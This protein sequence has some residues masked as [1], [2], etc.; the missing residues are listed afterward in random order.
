MKN[1]KKALRLSALASSADNPN[2]NKKRSNS[3]SNFPAAKRQNSYNKRP[4]SQSNFPAAK[5]QRSNSN[6]KLQRSQSVPR[7]NH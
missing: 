1:E 3:Q 5:R 6:P 2:S 7:I 4:N